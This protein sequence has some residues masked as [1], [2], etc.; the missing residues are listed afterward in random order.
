MFVL[1]SAIPFVLNWYYKRVPM[2]YLPPGDWFGP[3]G[4]L[5]SFPNA[6]A[7]AVS[8]TVWY[9]IRKKELT[10]RTT[11]CGRVLALVGEY[12]RELFVKDAY[13]VAEPPM[14]TE[15]SSGDKETTSKLSTNKP[16]AMTGEKFDFGK[17]V[18]E[19]DQ[20]QGILKQRRAN[21]SSD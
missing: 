15:K 2:F 7:G 4:Y 14:T 11:V 16:A 18:K 10:F 1:N 3:M 5:F 20:P 17:E 8:S 13:R 21:K 12:A 6:P 9:V 19:A